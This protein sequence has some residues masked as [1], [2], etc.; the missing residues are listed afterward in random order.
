MSVLIFLQLLMR[1]RL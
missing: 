1:S